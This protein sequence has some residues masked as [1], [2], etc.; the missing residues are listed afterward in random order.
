MSKLGLSICALISAS[1]L[2]TA[3]ADSGVDAKRQ[4][5]RAAAERLCDTISSAAI[6][7]GDSV[8]HFE[9][10]TLSTGEQIHA[11]L[12][13]DGVLMYS[14]EVSVVD[15]PCTPIHLWSWDGRD[16]NC[17]VIDSLDRSF[18]EL[19]AESGEVVTILA[20]SLVVD[21]IPQTVVFVAPSSQG[22]SR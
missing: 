1:I 5:L 3:F 17:S 4:E 14:G 12:T 21:Q 13:P 2:G 22:C 20:L 9:I 16:L 19:T 10:P 6:S 18:D 11:R 7:G 8:R 15:H